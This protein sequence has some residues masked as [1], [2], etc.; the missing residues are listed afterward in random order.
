MSRIMISLNKKI[1]VKYKYKHTIIIMYKETKTSV[2][3]MSIV[4]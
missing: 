2:K 3:M 1:N 4:G